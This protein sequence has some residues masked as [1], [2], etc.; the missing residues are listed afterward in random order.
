MQAIVALQPYVASTSDSIPIPSAIYLSHSAPL[1]GHPIV[2]STAV[3]LV[4][5][6]LSAAAYPFAKPLSWPFIAHPTRIVSPP[7]SCV[8]L[9]N[10]NQ[11]PT[12][13]ADQI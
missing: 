9:I 3:A 13:R 6:D 4:L 12:V 5:M 7:D 8:F 2:P 1:V 11:M 10:C